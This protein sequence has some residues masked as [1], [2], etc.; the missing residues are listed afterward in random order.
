MDEAIIK[1]V[2][3][4]GVSAVIALYLVRW[5]VTT[6]DKKLDSILHN[7]K[8]MADSTKTLA[9]SITKVLETKK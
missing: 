4:F 9:E 6:V 8:L 3:T 2:A 5:L 1:S 7:Q